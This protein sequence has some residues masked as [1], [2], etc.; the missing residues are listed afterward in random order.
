[1]CIFLKAQQ[2]ALMQFL[3]QNVG[4]Q[5]PS[6]ATSCPR[7]SG[8][9]PVPLRKPKTHRDSVG[10]IV[11]RPSTY[12]GSILG[13]G[14]RFFASP[15]HPHQLWDSPRLLFN[16]SWG[17]IPWKWICWHYQADHSP[18]PSA[19]DNNEW[20]YNCTIPHAVAVCIS[21]LTLTSRPI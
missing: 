18:L 8:S 5:L 16:G 3:S 11:T 20:I 12:C 9:S 4:I 6:G 14:K 13:R 1:M 10:G 15:K 17:L 21:I 7:R 2:T 19:E